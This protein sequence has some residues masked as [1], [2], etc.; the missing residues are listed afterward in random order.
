[1]GFGE[2]KKIIIKGRGWVGGG[3]ALT[4]IVQFEVE[5]AGVAHRVPVGVS[6]PQRRRCRL[7]VG[8][9]RPRPPGCR[10]Q[11]RGQKTN[12]HVNTK[13]KETSPE[14]MSQSGWKTSSFKGGNREKKVVIKDF[15]SFFANK[16][17][18]FF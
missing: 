9:G 18:C 13:R 15:F 4:Y 6:P 2:M 3:G 10:L 11:K 5:A 1:M 14:E 7:A 12:K 17:R 16:S 8:A